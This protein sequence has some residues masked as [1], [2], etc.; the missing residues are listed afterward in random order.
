MS[1]DCIFHCDPVT[2]IVNDIRKKYPTEVIEFID[3]F[4]FGFV[5]GIK[6]PDFDGDIE[7]GDPYLTKFYLTTNPLNYFNASLTF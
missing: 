6:N 7:N 4:S 1:K 3:D 2:T 5:I